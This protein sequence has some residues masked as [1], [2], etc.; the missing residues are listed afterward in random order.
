M[1]ETKLKKWG[2]TIFA[3]Y[4]LKELHW[5]LL[6]YYNVKGFEHVCHFAYKFKLLF[7][8]KFCHIESGRS[9]MQNI[10]FYPKHMKT[11]LKDDSC[12]VMEVADF[13]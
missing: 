2:T 5:K 12:L 8:Y 6:K 4:Q 13:I 9:I 1:K 3:N 10:H 11:K 7:T